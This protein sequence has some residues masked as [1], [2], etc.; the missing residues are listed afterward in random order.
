M[1]YLFFNGF[2]Y[3]TKLLLFI[4]FDIFY[5]N[6]LKLLPAMFTSPFNAVVVFLMGQCC[7]SEEMKTYVNGIS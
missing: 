3:C 1:F 2:L 7:L 5:Y 4:L 6:L